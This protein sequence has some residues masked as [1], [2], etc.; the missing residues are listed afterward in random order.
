MRQPWTTDNVVQDAKSSGLL[1]VGKTISK[2]TVL[3][4]AEVSSVVRSFCI[5]DVHVTQ[6]GWNFIIT[7]SVANPE[8]MDVSHRTVHLCN[9]ENGRLLVSRFQ[10]IKPRPKNSRFRQRFITA[11]KPRL[12][13]PVKDSLT[14]RRT[15]SLIGSLDARFWLAKIASHV[16]A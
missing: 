15:R 12:I 6:S 2:N 8:R 1:C 11:N 7:T 4:S 13:Q 10:W 5:Q 3:V 9:L 14:T 16:H